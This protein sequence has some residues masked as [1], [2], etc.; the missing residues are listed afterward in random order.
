M[1]EQAPTATDADTVDLQATI[2]SAVRYYMTAKGWT[3][4]RQVAEWLGWTEAKV[5]RRLQGKWHLD[6]IAVLAEKM[7]VG[8]GD[9]FG[10]PETLVALVRSR[11]FSPLSLV[12]D[13]GQMEL[14]FVATPALASV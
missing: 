3:T 1:T 9:L 10:D 11:C 5:S 7:E 2:T 14:A 13:S 4:Q 8:V 6:D 12:E